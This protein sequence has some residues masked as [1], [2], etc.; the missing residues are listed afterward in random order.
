M[1]A[2]Y[3]TK[4]SRCLGSGRFDRGTCFRCNGA[5]VTTTARKPAARFE[6]S[7]IYSDGV[8]RVMRCKA[9]KSA[10]A[11]I[12]AVMAEREWFGFDLATVAAK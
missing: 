12:T 6:V 2:T 10:E 7:A 9:A 5:G 8:R 4:C 3:T 1:K 11:A